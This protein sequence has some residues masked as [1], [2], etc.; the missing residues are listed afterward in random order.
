MSRPTAFRAAEVVVFEE[1]EGEVMEE[2]EEEGEVEEEEGEGEV[3]EEEE[4]GVDEEEEEV[5]EEARPSFEA[6]V[7]NVA[8]I[9]ALLPKSTTKPVPIYKN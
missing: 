8:N 5:V 6:T 7:S 9:S 1:E 3:E 4:E 2:D